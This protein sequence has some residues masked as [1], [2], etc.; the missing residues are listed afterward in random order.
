[1]TMR[2]QPSADFIYGPTWSQPLFSSLLSS[3]HLL[4]LN[5]DA[6]TFNTFTLLQSTSSYISFLITSPVMQYFCINHAQQQRPALLLDISPASIFQRQG[7]KTSC[8]CGLYVCIQ[9][10]ARTQVSLL[11]TCK[12][13]RLVVLGLFF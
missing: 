4:V 2:P 9:Q 1:M 3:F 5:L 12:Q 7:T 11:L 13:R 8:L 6:D 10:A